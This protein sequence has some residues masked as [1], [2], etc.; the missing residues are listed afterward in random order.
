MSPAMHAALAQLR[1]ELAATV[2]PK[3]SGQDIQRWALQ[4]VLDDPEARA[5]LEQDLARQ[6]PRSY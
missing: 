4:R 6:Y 1:G 3:V 5:Q 2:D